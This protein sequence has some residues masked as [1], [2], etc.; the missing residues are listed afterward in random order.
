M[1]TEAPLRRVT[2]L[3]R[4]RTPSLCVAGAL[5]RTCRLIPPPGSEYCGVSDMSKVPAFHTTSEEYSEDQRTV[6]NDNNKC[7]RQLW[8]APRPVRL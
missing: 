3:P 4:P 2:S 1:R 6:C 8:R 5:G 7:A